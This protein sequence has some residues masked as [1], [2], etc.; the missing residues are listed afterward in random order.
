MVIIIE[1]IWMK[2][3][4]SNNLPSVNKNLNT[5]IL[6]IGGGIA[7][8][9][10]AYNLMK[11]NMKFI[12]VDRQSLGTGVSAYTTAQ[13][14][15]A[16]DALYHEIAQKHGEKNA[17][18]YLKAQNEGLKIIKNIIKEENIE[19]NLKEESTILYSSV[20]KN[21]EILKYQY[22]LIKRSVKNIKL[23][24]FDNNPIKYKSAI[25]IKKQFII[26]PVKFML[27]IIDVLKKNKSEL[28]ENS[29]VTQINKDLKKYEVIINDKYKI[30]TDKIIMA[31]HYPF[32]NPDNLYFA[33]LL[34][35]KKIKKN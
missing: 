33:N 14:S 10:C 31:C 7:G 8:L 20:K 24:Y 29:V 11:K 15:I 6:I 2:D 17:V 27:G 26:N 30:L 16:H 34:N 23:L 28:Y 3:Y 22:E 13:I 5:P 1:S 12:L 32:L 18:L 19:C 35:D 21:I 4:K 25:E 9:M